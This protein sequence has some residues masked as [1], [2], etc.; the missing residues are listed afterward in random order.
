MMYGLSAEH[1]LSFLMGSTLL[2]VCIGENEAILRF[3]NEIS[4]TIESKFLVQDS[5][6]LKTTFDDAR[7]AAGPL[8]KLLSDT[9]T[10][11]LGQRDG[12]LRLCFT[13]GDILEIYD[14]FESYE[15][16]QIQHGT[17]VYVV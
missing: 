1:D 6:G 11:V 2:Q 15:S 17:D 13:R 10:K 4:I 16:Y 8:V 7:S 3:N 14:S 5:S 12:T 9:I